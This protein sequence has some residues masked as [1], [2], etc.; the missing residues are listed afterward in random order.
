MRRVAVG[1]VMKQE[2]PYI[3]EWVAYHRM[4]GFD[5]IIADNGGDDDTS[6]ILKGLHKIGACVRLDFTGYPTRP[7]IPAY[8]AMLRV[9]R[10]NDIEIIGFLD[11]DEF[12]SRSFPIAS[13]SPG[14]GAEYIL[15]EFERRDASQLSYHWVCYGSRCSSPNV[16]DPVLERFSWHSRRNERFNVYVKSFVRV[17]EMFTPLNLIYIGPPVFSPHYFS[18]ANRKWFIDGVRC[19]TF[20]NGKRVSYDMGCILHFQ[21]KSWGEYQSKI[22]RGDAIFR[23]NKNSR[24]YFDAHDYCDLCTKVD[25]AVIAQL[26]REIGDLRVRLSAVRGDVTGPGH[27]NGRLLSIGLSANGGDHGY[28]YHLMGILRKGLTTNK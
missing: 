7:Q 11:V 23:E 25:S 5:I 18:S 8:R 16:Q 26:K 27:V 20:D 14:D 6:E 1:A 13:V 17:R 10:K 12:F 2:A 19:H 9:A 15:N 4:L 21:I 22:K 28:P 3:L 24:S